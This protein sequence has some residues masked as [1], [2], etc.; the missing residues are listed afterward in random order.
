MK[1]LLTTIAACS[2][3]AV[4]ATAGETYV[5]RGDSKYAPTPTERMREGGLY[6]GLYG[7]VNVGQTADIDDEESDL[8]GDIESELDSDIGWFGGLKFGYVFP[9][10]SVVKPAIELDAFYMGINSELNTE[11]D[12]GDFD[13]SADFHS[14]VV[15]ANVKV[16]F[17]LGTFQPY[18]GAGLGYAH[19]WVDEVEFDGT[20]VEGA[21]SD[22]GTFAY[23]GIAGFD[24][25]L[26]ERLALFTEYK[27]VVLHDLGDVKNYVNH[28]V[29][30]GVRIGF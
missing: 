1:T 23:Q 19:T 9:T 16:Q 13:I 8:V 29:G 4:T 2:L 11:T 14:A 5:S 6:I 25:K 30:V 12:F 15:M 10:A 26:S 18:I 17:D 7:G 22:E 20:E 3:A 24:I 27:A 28:L 21:D